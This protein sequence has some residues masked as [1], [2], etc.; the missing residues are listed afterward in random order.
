MHSRSRGTR[1]RDCRVLE[2]SF[3]ALAMDTNKSVLRAFDPLANETR[4]GKE[5]TL[6]NLAL[7]TPAPKLSS[8]KFNALTPSALSNH[9]I[10]SLQHSKKPD[11]NILI[12]IGEEKPTVTH[13]ALSPHFGE[14]VRRESFPGKHISA[15]DISFNFGEQALYVRNFVYLLCIE[16]VAEGTFIGDGSYISDHPR[17][18][19]PEGMDFIFGTS[20]IGFCKLVLTFRTYRRRR[21]YRCLFPKFDTFSPQIEF[22]PRNH[23]ASHASHG[24]ARHLIHRTRL[25]LVSFCVSSS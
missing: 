10:N 6:Y 12:D 23:P 25:G 2:H 24:C 8:T 14:G 17:S 7:F 22:R 15:P 3:L 19:R 21:S 13:Q 5:N 11:S 4:I 9:A 16:R 1:Q 18:D 20:A